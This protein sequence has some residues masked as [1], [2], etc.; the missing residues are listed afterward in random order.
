MSLET[1]IR[2]HASRQ[3]QDVIAGIENV[4]LAELLKLYDAATEELQQRNEHWLEERFE[5][6]ERN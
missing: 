3:V 1:E 5:K 4:S 2:S 6:E